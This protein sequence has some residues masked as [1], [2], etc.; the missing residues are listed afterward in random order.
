M[1]TLDRLNLEA[2]YVPGMRFWRQTSDRRHG[3]IAQNANGAVEIWHALRDPE[4]GQVVAHSPTPREAYDVAMECSVLEATCHSKASFIGYG[5]DFFPLLQSG[6][7][8]AVLQQLADW[9][10][11]VFAAK[12]V[13]A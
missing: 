1:I 10:D 12:A 7:E 6:D 5:H 9:H 13:P 11:E 4:V 2:L 3:I 8:R